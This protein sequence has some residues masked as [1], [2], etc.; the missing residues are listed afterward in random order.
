VSPSAIVPV[1]ID[2]VAFRPELRELSH[3]AAHRA[4][5]NTVEQVYFLKSTR[6]ELSAS[7]GAACLEARIIHLDLAKRYGVKAAEAADE[8]RMGRAYGVCDVARLRLVA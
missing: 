1:A 7:V 6:E 4:G 5:R 3:S 2:R 8:A